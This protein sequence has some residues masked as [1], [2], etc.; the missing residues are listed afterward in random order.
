MEV[1][2]IPLHVKLFTKANQMQCITKSTKVSSDG[3]ILALCENNFKS[4]ILKCISLAGILNICLWKYTDM[5]PDIILDNSISWWRHQM[6]TFSALLAICAGNSPVPGELIAQRPVARSFHVFFDL[7]PNER[8]S[9]QSWAWW[10]DA[11][12]RPLWCHSNGLL[13]VPSQ[14]QGWCWKMV[15]YSVYRNWCL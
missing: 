12:S 5:P 7:Q 2:V 4:A 10:F 8:L 15:P 1:P 13:M 9:K 6:E 11:P 3:I 14:C